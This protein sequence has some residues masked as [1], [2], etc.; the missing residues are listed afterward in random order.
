M[1][2]YS[3]VAASAGWRLVRGKWLVRQLLFA[4]VIGAASLSLYLSYVLFFVIGQPCKLCLIAHGV[5]LL[6]AGVVIGT[7]MAQ[8]RVERPVVLTPG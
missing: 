3:L 6:M 1:I 7:M 8:R 2:F 4:G 5:N